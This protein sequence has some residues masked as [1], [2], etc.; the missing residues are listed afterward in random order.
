MIALSTVWTWVL[1]GWAGVVAATL[2]ILTAA[3]WADEVQEREWRRH[4]AAE[5]LEDVW[6]IPAV[7][8]ARRHVPTEDGGPDLLEEDR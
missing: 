4:K 7:R 5:E 6:E 1:I 8:P 3:K 2:A